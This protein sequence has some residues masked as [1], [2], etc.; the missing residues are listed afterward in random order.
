MSKAETAGDR[1]EMGADP[2]GMLGVIERLEVGPVDLD[3]NRMT[4]PYRITQ[5]GRTSSTELV[6][7]FEEAVFVPEERSS[8]N[9]AEMLSVQ[10]ALNYGLFC[11]EVVLHGLFDAHDRRFIE[12]M[13][14][15]T[16]REIFVK[17]FLQPVLKGAKSI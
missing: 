12:E 3:S 14:R 17:K 13:A 10:V 11:N 6:Y 5:N 1:G 7:R 16:S 2:L 9:L 4:A 8:V 15:K